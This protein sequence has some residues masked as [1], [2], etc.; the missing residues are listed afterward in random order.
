[1][2]ITINIIR[3]ILRSA[4]FCLALVPSAYADGDINLPCAQKYSGDD[5]ERLKCYDQ[6]VAPASAPENAPLQN[7]VPEAGAAASATPAAATERSYLTQ[8]WNLDDLSNRDPSK[9]GRI[10]PYR[11]TYLMLKRTGNPNRQPGSPAIGRSTL[12]PND[13]D[14]SEAK[15]QLSFKADIGNQ[16]N[17]DFLGIS[18]VR[19]WWAYTQQSNWQVFNIRNSSPYRETVYEPELIAT[20]GTGHASGLKLINLGWVHQSNGRSL[21]ESRGWYRV[22]VQGGWEWNDMTS[23]L[24]RGWRRVQENP[25]KDDNPDII[26]YAGRADLVIRWE[27]RDKSQAI[28]IL[29]RN[30]LHGTNNRGYAQIDW[31]TPVNV[32]HAARM[33][34]QVTSGYG[35]SLIDYNHHQNTISLGFSFREW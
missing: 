18:T 24:L 11:Q 10:Q 2:K 28:A 7:V 22:Y 27:P 15:F 6:L 19:F 35:E 34:I 20:L 25:L 1:M 14:M 23:V 13:I 21:P 30:N 29:L 32:G 26:E 17:I 4:F 5:V 33:H 12:A 31:A 3:N 9:L 16:R 8:L